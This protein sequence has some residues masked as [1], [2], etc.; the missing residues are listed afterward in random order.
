M[1]KLAKGTAWLLGL[2]GLLLAAWFGI[3]GTDEALSDQA[4][5]TMVVPALPEPSADNGFFDYLALGA[6]ADLPAFEAGRERLTVLNGAAGADLP[7]S[8]WES[9]SA[10]PRLRCTFGAV[11]GS[12]E[13][14]A[15]LDLA[16]REP[17]VPAVL[18]A[19]ARL[20]DRYRAMREKPYFVNLLEV[21]SPEQPLPAYLEMLEAQ[22]MVLLGAALRFHSG[23]RSGAARELERD[24]RFYRTMARQ[25]TMLIDKMI[26]FVA[27]DRLALFAVE[28][29]RRSPRGDAA[30]WR[31]LEPAIAPMTKAELDV[32]PVLRRELAQTARW[33]STRRFVRISESTWEAFRAFDGRTRP[34]WEPVAPYLYRP[35]QIVNWFAAN[36]PIFLAVGERPA[37]E[38]FRA[39]E[40]AR[41]RARTLLPG[42]VTRA[43][44]SPAGWN[45]PLI[46]NCDG[47]EYIARAHARAGVQ[48]LARLLVSL[49]ARGITSPEAVAAA[50]AGP[51]G[52]AH[53]DPFTGKPMRYDAVTGTIGF[54]AEATHL[55][56]VARPLRQRYGRMA[57]A[58]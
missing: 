35:H 49:R 30:F 57:L 38:F 48:A 39:T 20:L 29:A 1:G 28:L 18:K 5:A 46:S 26:A 58:L 43:V 13:A 40:A 51:L 12:G 23:D 15:C 33:M 25:A 24:A 16:T 14:R 54:D 10:E 31:A 8:P 2:G 19:H 53:A 44:L 50:L 37:S 9:F 36:C 55:S 45:H 52:E 42:P 21:K 7:P 22:R 32:A 17:W 3:N 6:P 4:R 47:T 11:G 27:L 34:W 56:G 41:E